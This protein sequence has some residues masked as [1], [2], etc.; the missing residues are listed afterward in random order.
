M[1]EKLST[2][3]LI[4]Q[5][6]CHTK[7]HWKNVY[8]M[9]PIDQEEFEYT[10]KND[11]NKIIKVYS[12]KQVKP[13]REVKSKPNSAL[14]N[15][16]AKIFGLRAS[17]KNNEHKFVI[18]ERCKKTA[19]NLIDANC[20][21]IDTETTGLDNPYV[22]EV[23]AVEA[24][25]GNVLVDTLIYTDKNIEDSAEAVHGITKE[26]LIDKPD[27]DSV[28]SPILTEAGKR[29]FA[30]YN[31]EF[32]RRALAISTKQDLNV[33]KHFKD[34]HCIMLLATRLI[35]NSYD[36]RYVSLADAMSYFDLEWQGDSHR[37][38]SDTLAAKDVLHAIA[39][40]EI[41]RD[42]LQEQLDK[43]LKE[44]ELIKGKAH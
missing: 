31:I 19:Q 32:D 11:Y 3:E 41:E 16:N 21:V 15:I 33:Q 27:L 1:M 42:S 26:L 29:P 43:L 44:K 23:A 12:Y 10:Y 40:I 38:L 7:T 9:K 28:L 30:S 17:L 34:F 20:I 2:K 37:A 39:N 36:G 13:M 18:Q 24:R 14:Q 6:P 35:T 22:V 4:K 5:N 25:T 8:R